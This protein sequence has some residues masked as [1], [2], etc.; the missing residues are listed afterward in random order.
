MDETSEA[1]WAR[2]R[3]EKSGGGKGESEEGGERVRVGG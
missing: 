2:V 3:T 1:D